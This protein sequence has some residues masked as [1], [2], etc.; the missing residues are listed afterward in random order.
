MQR[1]LRGTALLVVGLFVLPVLADDEKKA[2]DNKKPDVEKKAD[3]TKKPDVAKKADEKKDAGDKKANDKDKTVEKKEVNKPD[4]V[5]AGEII[6]RI[7][8][9]DEG[10]KSIK[11]KVT[12]Q[13]TKPNEGEINALAQAQRNLQLATLRGDRN[14]MLNHQA[15]IAY[16]QARIL[17]VEEKNQDVEIQTTDEPPADVRMANPPP[18]FDEKGNP[19]KYTAKELRELKEK[20]PKPRLPGYPAEFSDLHLNQIVKVTL[21]RK[22]DLPKR[23]KG[24][25]VDPDLLADFLPKA[26]MILILYQAKE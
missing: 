19:K 21:V 20:D 12:Y 17:R 9:L 6:G 26:S 25:D 24:K 14:A 2:T 10:K 11:I 1:I 5:K 13:V 4:K 18:Q 15:E 3:D 8:H 7:V 16:H 23:P 22:K